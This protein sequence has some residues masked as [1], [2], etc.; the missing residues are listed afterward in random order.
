MI[1]K[2]KRSAEKSVEK[3]KKYLA[4]PLGNGDLFC[5]IDPEGGMSDEMPSSP[6]LPGYGIYRAGVR[7]RQGRPLSFGRLES[8]TALGGKLLPF[9]KSF[10]DTLE[11]RRGIYR[12]LAHYEFGLTVKTKAAVLSGTPCLLITRKGESGEAGLRL[13]LALTLPSDPAFTAELSGGMILIRYR[14]EKEAHTLCFTTSHPAKSELKGGR[15]RLSVDC[16][17]G[18]SVAFALF[19]ADGKAPLTEIAAFRE[20]LLRGGAGKLLS[21]HADTWEKAFLEGSLEPENEALSSLYHGSR[22]LLKCFKTRFGTP[23]SPRHREAPMGYA[24]ASDLLAVSALL[25]EGHKKE[26]EEL[27]FAWCERLPAALSR[28]SAPGEGFAHFPFYADEAGRELLA[29]DYR[30][31]FLLQDA[32][33]LLAIAAYARESGDLA[34]LE[35][36]GFPTANAIASY[37]LDKALV[38]RDGGYSYRGADPSSAGSMPKNPHLTHLFL[39][40]ALSAYAE[41]SGM[42]HREKE[43]ASA[44]SAVSSVLLKTLP[45]EKGLYARSGTEK[46]PTPA[47]LLT[48]LLPLSLPE[49]KYRRSILWY[50]DGRREHTPLSHAL[51]AAS[52]ASIHSSIETPLSA[53]IGQIDRFGFL[54]LA[55]E[56]GI[57]D[58]PSA[59]ILALRHALLDERDGRIYIGFGFHRVHA[60]DL[61]FTL[62]TKDGLLSEGRIRDGKLVALS[63][64]RRRGSAQKQVDLVIPAWLYADGAIPALKKVDRG[65]IYYISAPVK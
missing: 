16:K 5:C 39:S 24:P 50:R 45:T 21:E 8:E 34:F 3:C 25:A 59:V 37:L 41:L 17:K 12:A 9:P 64:K 20:R 60:E 6:F 31:S 55:D 43:R 54:P 10:E 56:E 53:L 52:F 1:L 57:T 28:V 19:F 18:T 11:H 58:T 15:A 29:D 32:S 40:A 26:A 23:L 36:H 14:T 4:P 2:S 47:V 46:S 63:F 35:K 62:P 7:D 27:L 30:R 22:Y 65:G 38:L 51:T 42:L 44:A 49:D 61:E 33:L 48:H 13:S